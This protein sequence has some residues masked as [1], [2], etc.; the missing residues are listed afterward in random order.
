[1]NLVFLEVF[2]HKVIESILVIE[3]A[4]R[5]ALKDYCGNIY[6]SILG[7]KNYKK[8]YHSQNVVEDP[9]KTFIDFCRIN[10]IHDLMIAMECD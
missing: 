4:Y 3:M 7:L 5:Q 6:L 8:E 1:M 10:F 9:E 2:S